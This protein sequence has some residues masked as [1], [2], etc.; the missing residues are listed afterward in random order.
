MIELNGHKFAKNQ[1]EFTETLFSN[2]TATGYYKVTKTGII[3][4]DHQEKRIGGISKHG[5]CYRSTKLKNGKYWHQPAAPELIGGIGAVSC[6]EANNVLK[7]AV[8][9]G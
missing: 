6:I 2:K 4:Y 3:L 8:N 1:K 7:E 5:V 9:H